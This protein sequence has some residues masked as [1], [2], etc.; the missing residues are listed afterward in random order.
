MDSNSNYT[1]GRFVR[2]LGVHYARLGQMVAFC[3]QLQVMLK[4]GLE[5]ES[6]WEPSLNDA[7]ENLIST[8]E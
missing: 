3:I 7:A 5:P 6:I 1:Q 8:Q 4:S 2:V